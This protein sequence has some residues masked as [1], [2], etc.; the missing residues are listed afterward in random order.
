MTSKR[1]NLRNLAIPWSTLFLIRTGCI[2]LPIKLWCLRTAR[3]PILC[4]QNVRRRICPLLLATSFSAR[5]AFK[6]MERRREDGFRT[7][8][9]NGH[10]S[11]WRFETTDSSSRW[12]CSSPRN[13]G[14]TITVLP[15]GCLWVS[16]AWGRCTSSARCLKRASSWLSMEARS[17]ATTRSTTS[18][19]HSS[20]AGRIKSR[21]PIFKKLS[22]VPEDSELKATK[23][24][25]KRSKNTWRGTDQSLWTI[26]KEPS[27][28]WSQSPL[29]L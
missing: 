23:Y 3:L 27:Q 6:T 8:L 21:T 2:W 10:T 26:I 13:R 20:T 7:R 12:P 16:L 24:Q 29:L 22:A 25:M 11:P 1:E 4:T 18:S 15:D 17:S 5:P 9:S 28:N 19:F 14:M